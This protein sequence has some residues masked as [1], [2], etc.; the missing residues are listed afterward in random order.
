MFKEFSVSNGSTELERIANF[1]IV[2]DAHCLIENPDF[3][4]LG[5]GAGFIADEKAGDNNDSGYKKRKKRYNYA[6][7]GADDAAKNPLYRS[8]D[9][10]VPLRFM[11]GFC[12]TF[13]RLTSNFSYTFSYTSN[14]PVNIVTN[15]ERT[16]ATPVDLYIIYAF[17]RK[18]KLNMINN[19]SSKG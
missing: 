13:N 10:F 7:Q 12:N 14:S 19:S 11:S 5:S 16:A 9:V 15:I 4:Q 8:V 17:E 6:L 2:Y 3:I 1:G 18:V